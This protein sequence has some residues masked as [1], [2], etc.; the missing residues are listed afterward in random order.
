MHVVRKYFN[1]YDI[2]M[3]TEFQANMG[4]KHF[5]VSINTY[6]VIHKT[7]YLPAFY[8]QKLYYLSTFLVHNN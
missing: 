3:I 5:S 4:N 1:S 6:M 8:L 7:L 2:D